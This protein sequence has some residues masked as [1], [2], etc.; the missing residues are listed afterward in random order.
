MDINSEKQR[1]ETLLK[2]SGCVNLIGEIQHIFKYAEGCE[3]AMNNLLQ[4]RKGKTNTSNKAAISVKLTVGGMRFTILEIL[5]NE[6]LT[7]QELVKRLDSKHQTVSARISELAKA[8]FIEVCGETDTHQIY[9]TTKLGSQ[10]LG[11]SQL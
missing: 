6:K 3:R 5:Q 11:D 1:I 9:F 10:H 8:G 7:C 4:P 2:E